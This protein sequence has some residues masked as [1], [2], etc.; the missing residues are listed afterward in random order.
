[1]ASRQRRL[2]TPDAEMAGRL[3]D[4]TNALIDGWVNDGHFDIVAGVANEVPARPL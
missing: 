4:T 3:R 2:T 1:M